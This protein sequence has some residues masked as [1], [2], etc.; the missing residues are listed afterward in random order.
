NLDLSFGQSSLGFGA[1]SPNN[2]SQFSRDL[3]ERLGDN[4]RDTG[5]TSAS[6][7]W[8]FADW[9]GLAIT[10]SQSSGSGALLGVISGAAGTADTLSLGISARVGFG[11]GWVTTIAYSGGVTQLDLSRSGLIANPETLRSRGV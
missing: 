5:T 3:G 2:P 4:L 7:S 11:E 6:I 1:L 10:A 8:N 9:G